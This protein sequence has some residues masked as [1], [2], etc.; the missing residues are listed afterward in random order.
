M[1]NDEFLGRLNLILVRQSREINK[2]TRTIELLEK[3]IYQDKRDEKLE[4]LK[5]NAIWEREI[6]GI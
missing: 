1:E 4:K 5:Y 2:L 6:Y 3:K